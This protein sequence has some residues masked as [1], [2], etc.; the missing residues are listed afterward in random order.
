MCITKL[1]VVTPAQARALSNYRLQCADYTG[2]ALVRFSD[3]DMQ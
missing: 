2:T 1:C 3:Y